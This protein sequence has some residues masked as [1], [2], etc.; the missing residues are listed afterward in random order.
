MRYL[1]QSPGC[2]CAEWRGSAGGSATE[3]TH[4]PKRMVDYDAEGFHK[5]KSDDKQLIAAL[6]AKASNTAPPNYMDLFRKE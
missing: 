2:V 6:G 5:F 3:H 1:W 4:A